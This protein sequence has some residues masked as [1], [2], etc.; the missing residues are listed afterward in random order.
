MRT[1][2]AHEGEP[3]TAE[4]QINTIEEV[5]KAL[6]GGVTVTNGYSFSTKA[7]LERITKQ[8]PDKPEQWND[9]TGK[10]RVG[11]QRDTEVTCAKL[12]RGGEWVHARKRTKVTQVYASAVSVTYSY[13][14]DDT[15]DLEQRKKL[16]NQWT[17]IWSKFARLVLRAAYE[18]TLRVAL[19]VG[20]KTVVLTALGGGVFGNKPEWIAEAIAEA[21]LTFKYAGLKIV[22][23]QFDEK[24]KVAL[25]IVEKLLGSG[26]LQSVSFG[27]WPRPIQMYTE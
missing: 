8:I 23:N 27:A 24:D 9:L 16:R 3:Q 5:V 21:V 2:F 13:T 14:D 26:L 10:V 25:A 12:R 11:V 6:G 18:A 22:F 7:D 19:Q 15:L 4:K 20:A 1:Y 17:Q